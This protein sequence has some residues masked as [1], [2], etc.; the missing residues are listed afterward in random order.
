[1]E[2]DEV[3]LSTIYYKSQ[4]FFNR[5][6]FALLFYIAGLCL[7]LP[8]HLSGQFTPGQI[9]GLILVLSLSH[10]LQFFLGITSQIILGSDQKAYIKEILQGTANILN[11]LLTLVLIQSGQTILMVKFASALIFILPPLFISFYVRRSYK[12]SKTLRDRTYQIQ[13]QWYGIGQHIAYTIQESTDIV[14]LSMFATLSQVSVYAVYNTVFQGIKTFLNAATSGLRPF[15]GRALHMEEQKLL[16]RQFH[17]MEWLLHTSSTIFISSTF[18]LVTP[19]VVLYTKKITDANY[20]QPLFGY[21]MT[22]AI[23][24]YALRLPYRTLVFSKG[25]FKN[26]QFGTY[27]EAVLN[28]GLSLALVFEWQI[29]GVAIGTAVALFFSLIYYMWY[30]YSHILKTDLRLLNK[31]L[32]VDAGV[33]LLSNLLLLPRVNKIESFI[34]WIFFGFISIFLTTFISYILNRIVLNKNLLHFKK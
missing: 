10:L 13:Q 25:D 15:L 17:K 1:M 22:L 8:A 5:I 26:T 32:L 4:A 23:L 19:F 9:I 18:Q 21:L 20:N 34:S 30:S 27:F 28:L 16:Q 29:V 31:Q 11:L 12:I 6:G 24:F 3:L 14:I 2:N 33:F 7:F